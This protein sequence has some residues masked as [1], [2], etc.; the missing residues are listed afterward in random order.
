M[1]SMRSG[2]LVIRTG[3]GD[4]RNDYFEAGIGRAVFWRDRPSN[5][6]PT[7]VAMANG[8]LTTE[9][10][11]KDAHCLEPF[12]PFFRSARIVAWQCFLIPPNTEEK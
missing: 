10:Q 4:W 8:N 1:I 11:R 12:S 5:Q 2:E 7:A 6:Y 3:A 9:V